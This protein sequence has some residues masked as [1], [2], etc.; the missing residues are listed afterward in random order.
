MS[1]D[2]EEFVRY[3]I[4]N[5]QVRPYP[6]PHFYV[7]SV[8]P[9]DFYRALQ[10][11]LPRTEVL[12]PIEEHGTV[13]VTDKTTGEFRPTSEPRY[14]AD[15]SKLEEDE[16]QGQRGHLWRDLSAWLLSDAF[17]DL[18]LQ[19]FRIGIG[20]RFGEGAQLRTDVEGRFVRDFH[21]YKIHPH[22]D[23]PAKLV[24]LLFYLPANESLRH[25][26][27]VIYRPLDPQLRCKGLTRHPFELFRKV[28]T[29]SFMPNALFGFFK[30]DYSFH[31]VEEIQDERIERNVLLYNIYVRKVV[32][33][34]RQETAKS[35]WPWA[36]KPNA[37]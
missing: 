8:F 16:E 24:S 2:V 14:I 26:G 21:Q 35:I 29:M 6:F 18:M 12:E 3:Q 31:G 25:H 33:P 34:Q 13:G 19:K 9:D 27:T 36:R 20:E 15:L 17:R 28:A 10:A 32:L 4:A 1:F 5:A 11:S 23:Q 30:T 7:G 22:T 37:A